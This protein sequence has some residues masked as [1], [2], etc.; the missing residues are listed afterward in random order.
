MTI[1]MLQDRTGQQVAAPVAGLRLIVLARLA[2]GDGTTRSELSRDL[3]PIAGGPAGRLAVDVELAALV[4]AGHAMENRS[5]FS[6]T[7][8]GL[9]VASIALGSKAMPR[10]WA[11]LRDVRL[12]ASALGIA[13]EPPGRLKQLA[14]PDALR[15]AILASTYGFKL[16]GPTTPSK[17]RAEL[18]LVALERAFGNK[19]KSGLPTRGGFN[20]KTSR[21][22]AGQLLARPRD[23]GTDSRLI[24]ALA[25]EAAGSAKPDAEALRVA[26]LRKFAGLTTVTAGSQTT[27]APPSTATPARPA[28]TI[29]QRRQSP[30]PAST[31]PVEPEPSA[32]AGL[33]RPA[34]ASRPDLPG[35]AAAVQV[36]A[37]TCADGWPGNRKALVSRVWQAISAAH[38]GW[39]LSAI[40]F[41][42]MLA[43]AHRTGHLVLATAD[44]R[45]KSLLKELQESAITYKN[46]VWHQ[47]RVAD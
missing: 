6:P 38:P 30:T 36:A 34:A 19:I 4:R 35:F 12:V 3:G 37:R 1:A 26:V 13:Q 17:L 27:A 43:E 14:K 22:L 21:T 29:A 10:T 42:A 25:A 15:A 2:L 18:A 23:A 39:G 44:L 7:P 45:D 9:K 41:K 47:L 28:G 33:A 16:R 46:T 31:D 20:A 40:E 8:N 32:T 11:E 24:T 5:R